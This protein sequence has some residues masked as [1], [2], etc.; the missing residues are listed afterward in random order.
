MV[1][2]TGPSWPGQVTVSVTDSSPEDTC[3]VKVQ[4]KSDAQRVSIIEPK[5]QAEPNEQP[6]KKRATA[7]KTRSRATIRII[8]EDGTFFQIKR[9]S[10]PISAIAVAETGAAEQERLEPAPK[11]ARRPDGKGKGGR[12]EYDDTAALEKMADLVDEGMTV[13]AAAKQCASAVPNR[14]EQGVSTIRR[15]SEKFRKMAQGD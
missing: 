10:A 8:R 2:I 14:G 9:R 3:R 11:K 6:P 5:P 7:D 15:L 4:Q 13:H 12:N 1:K